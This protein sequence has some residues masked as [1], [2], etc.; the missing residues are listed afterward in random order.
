MGKSLII[1]GAVV[2]AFGL[3][4]LPPVAD[5][6]PVSLNS[7]FGDSHTYYRVVPTSKGSNF[8]PAFLIAIG[9]LLFG[10]GLAL[11]RRHKRG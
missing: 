7:L 11:H 6:L 1:F 3:L 2:L 10:M 9:L 5:L 4:G 8:V